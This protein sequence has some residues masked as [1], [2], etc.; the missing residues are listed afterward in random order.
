MRRVFFFAV[1]LSISVPAVSCGA[2]FDCQ[3]ASTAVESI[4]C[5]QDEL[6]ELDERMGWTYAEARRK[7]SNRKRLAVEQNKW[8]VERNACGR[9]VVCLR[10]MYELRIAAL[11]E[12][13][14]A[15][16]HRNDVK[17]EFI[18]TRNINPVC[19]D[20]RSNLNEF[21]HMDFDQCHPR[22]S[23]KFPQ[24]TRPQWKEVPLD[25]QISERAFK[26]L[27]MYSVRSD[28]IAD[29]ERRWQKWLQATEKIRA[30]GDLKMWL[31]DVDVDN[32]EVIDTIARVQYAIPASDYPIL[33]R[34]CVYSHSGLW[35]VRAADEEKAKLFNSRLGNLSDIVLE[36]N[37]RKTYILDW[38]EADVGP[39]YMGRNIG[40]TR[41]V[42]VNMA[43]FLHGPV[44]MC[45]INWVPEGHFHYPGNYEL[46]QP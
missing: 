9:G 17:G 35:I 12:G 41:G 26:G 30:N 43:G 14:G 28:A 19:V 13:R 36:S 10:T 39:E 5:E 22:L 7:S 42:R 44:P 25:L 38:Y 37:T 33:K 40:A 4:I 3:K 2:S 18:L 46:P 32:D 15:E 20:F 1:F 23:E 16:R 29:A 11:L 45:H 21:R 6:S 34:G 24:F 8:L 27:S 31:A